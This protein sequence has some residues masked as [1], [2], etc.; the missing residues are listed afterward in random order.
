MLLP[1]VGHRLGLN[2]H[3]APL[4]I[5]TR[6]YLNTRRKVGGRLTPIE[7]HCAALFQEAKHLQ[8][9]ALSPLSLDKLEK[10]LK[11]SSKPTD[12]LLV[13]IG[14]SGQ[15]SKANWAQLQPIALGE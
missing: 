3:K 10:W 13:T 11:A 15:L 8:R 5:V 1:K 6:H 7:S 4:R 2:R 12:S 14:N 9:I